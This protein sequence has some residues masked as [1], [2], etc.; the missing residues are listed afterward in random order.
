M[1][2]IYDNNNSKTVKVLDLALVREDYPKLIQKV[3]ILQTMINEDNVKFCLLVLINFYH[4]FAPYLATASIF[5]L[6]SS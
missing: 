6:I 2:Q 4:F 3:L 1:I 5:F